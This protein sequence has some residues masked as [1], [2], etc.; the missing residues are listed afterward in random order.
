MPVVF[1]SRTSRESIW[2][3][4]TM[5]RFLRWGNWPVAPQLLGGSGCCI[6]V[7]DDYIPKIAGQVI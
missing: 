3:G 4:A 1:G 7:D 5:G 2:A 6:V